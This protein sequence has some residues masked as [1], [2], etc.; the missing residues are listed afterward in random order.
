MI[1]SHKFEKLISEKRTKYVI[2]ADYKTGLQLDAT[3]K[4]LLRL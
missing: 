4:I 3:I 2:P 1:V